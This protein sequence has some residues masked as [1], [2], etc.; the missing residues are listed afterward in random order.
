MGSFNRGF[1]AMDW[2]CKNSW[3]NLLTF[4]SSQL[5]HY[6]NQTPRNFNQRNPSFRRFHQNCTPQAQFSNPTLHCFYCDKDGHKHREANQGPW[7]CPDYLSKK[8]PCQSWQKYQSDRG[9]NPNPFAVLN[10]TSDKRE[11]ALSRDIA[12]KG[13]TRWHYNLITFLDLGGCEN[14]VNAS[15]ARNILQLPIKEDDSSVQCNFK[16]YKERVIFFW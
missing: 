10:D 14:V 16:G 9:F 15:F 8:A 4:S 11:V 13:N 1:Q 6:N 7:R 3:E 5:P 12:F 2:W